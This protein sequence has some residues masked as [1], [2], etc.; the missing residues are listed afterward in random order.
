[1]KISDF[2]SSGEDWADEF[3][4]PKI[5]HN[6]TQDANNRADQAYK[7]ARVRERGIGRFKS[8]SQKQQFLSA[9]GS[10]CDLFNLERQL[11]RAKHHRELRVSAFSERI[12]AVALGA[13]A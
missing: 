1:M 2:K 3:L 8:V 11:V 9:H 5:I 6:R 13:R 7:P 10:V 12:R 4:I